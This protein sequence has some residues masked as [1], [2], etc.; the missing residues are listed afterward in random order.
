LKDLVPGCYDPYS[1]MLH[2]QHAGYGRPLGYNLEQPG[3]IR[4]LH[5]IYDV[6]E[7]LVRIRT[8]YVQHCQ[9]GASEVLRSVEETADNLIAPELKAEVRRL[10][11]GVV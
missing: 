3:T 1:M 2:C 4:I 8:K 11:A 5:P 9:P 7:F 6:P 10:L